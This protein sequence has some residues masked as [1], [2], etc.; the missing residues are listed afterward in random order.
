MMNTGRRVWDRAHAL[1]NLIDPAAGQIA[2]DP[3]MDVYGG[4]NGKIHG[5]IDLEDY[6][7]NYNIDQGKTSRYTRLMDR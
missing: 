4:A 3:M 2:S 5:F 1:G 7:Y 6:T